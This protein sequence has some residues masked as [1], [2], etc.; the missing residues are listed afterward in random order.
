MVLFVRCWF[1]CEILWWK[2]WMSSLVRWWFLGIII[3]CLVKLLIKFLFFNFLLIC[4]RLFGLSIGVK[5]KIEFFF[6]DFFF[7]MVWILGLKV[8]FWIIWIM[9]CFVFEIIFV[10]IFLVVF[11]F[12]YFLMKFFKYVIFRISFF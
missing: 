8:F 1:W 10:L 12:L 5:D 6:S 4:K 9:K 3:G 7:L 11:I 2:W